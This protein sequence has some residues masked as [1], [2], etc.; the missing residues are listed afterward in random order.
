[1]NFDRV[2]RWNNFVRVRKRDRK[3]TYQAN[4]VKFILSQG[5][6]R[7]I[8]VIL[9]NIKKFRESELKVLTLTK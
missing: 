3:A 5:R 9:F 7:M 6:R 4:L 2:C 8:M 1:M